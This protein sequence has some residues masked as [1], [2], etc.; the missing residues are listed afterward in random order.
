MTTFIEA[1]KNYMI[2]MI[3]ILNSHVSIASSVFN[4]LHT[5]QFMTKIVFL[6][7]KFFSCS[8]NF[9]FALCWFWTLI[10]SCICC[11]TRAISTKP[12]RALIRNNLNKYSFCYLIFQQYV[13]WTNENKNLLLFFI[14]IVSGLEL[15]KKYCFV[16]KSNNVLCWVWSFSTTTMWS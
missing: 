1:E 9:L 10:N 16:R 12:Q 6:I 15:R 14:L 7:W 4:F 13:Y 2:L 8:R 11:K 3:L 5:M